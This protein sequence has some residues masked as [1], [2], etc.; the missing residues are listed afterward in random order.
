LPSDS[1]HMPSEQHKRCLG[2]GYILDGLPEN[3]CP[4][5]GRTFDLKNPATYLTK[6]K[7]GR[8]Y[9]FLA[10]L[11]VAILLLPLSVAELGDLGIL[12]NVGNWGFAVILALTPAMPAAVVLETY[13][14]HVVIREFRLPRDARRHP[15][16]WLAALIISLLTI[17]AFVGLL[18][19]SWFL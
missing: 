16:C 10:V 3:R 15:R 5:C 4:E 2:C 6:L 1:V 9:L 7:S 14:L 8:R 19:S 17:G 18:V 11:G 12:A 13:V